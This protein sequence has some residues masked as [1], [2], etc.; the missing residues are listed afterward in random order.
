MQDAPNSWQVR[1]VYFGTGGEIYTGPQT[2]SAL[3]SLK[4][5]S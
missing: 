4:V 3:A 2:S 5:E 1:R